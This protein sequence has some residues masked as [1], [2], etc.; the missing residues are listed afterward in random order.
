MRFC[1]TAVYTNVFQEKIALLEE[2]EF[3]SELN[4]VR[5]VLEHDMVDRNRSVVAEIVK[6]NCT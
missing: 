4:S 2:Q 6:D 1:H 5:V 3:S